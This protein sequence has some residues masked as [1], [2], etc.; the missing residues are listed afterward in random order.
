M[1]GA[2]NVLVADTNSSH[3]GDLDDSDEENASGSENNNIETAD[4][5]LSIA[6]RY[7]SYLHNMIEL[8]SAY[9]LAGLHLLLRAV[10]L[11]FIKIPTDWSIE[12]R[13]ILSLS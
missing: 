12:L 5:N 10:K 3:S 8:S 4:G 11:L 6:K 9:S 13:I 2:A 1:V 7:T